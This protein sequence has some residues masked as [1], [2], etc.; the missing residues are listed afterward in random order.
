TV[1]WASSAEAKATVSSS[2]L[3][4][5]AA[6]GSTV[7]TATCGDAVAVCNVTVS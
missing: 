1:T 5:G 4:T 6:S 2:G 3:V 7:I